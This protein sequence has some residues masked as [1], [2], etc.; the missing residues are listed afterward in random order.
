MRVPAGIG[1]DM[2]AE[3]QL[4]LCRPGH[5]SIP[6]KPYGRSYTTYPVSHPARTCIDVFSMWNDG[7]GAFVFVVALE[8]S[9]LFV[10]CLGPRPWVI[11]GFGVSAGDT[12]GETI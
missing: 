7:F 3:K 4:G 11:V 2:C 1:S 8:G 12:R 9:S 10:E 5:T 6:T